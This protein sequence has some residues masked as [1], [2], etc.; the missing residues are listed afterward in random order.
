MNQKFNILNKLDFAE[1]NLQNALDA[2]I[3][4]I[5]DGNLPINGEIEMATEKLKRITNLTRTIKENL[6]NIKEIDTKRKELI[7]VMD[8]NNE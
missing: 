5:K 2:E 1:E 4:L 6:E 7:S 8:K 3:L